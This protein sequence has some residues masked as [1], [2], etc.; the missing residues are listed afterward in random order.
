MV[1]AAPS[2]H[3]RNAGAELRGWTRVRS[4]EFPVVA[5]ARYARQRRP[6]H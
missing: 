6:S 2:Q 5:T 3:K 1:L 4:R